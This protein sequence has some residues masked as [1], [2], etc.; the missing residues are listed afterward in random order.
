METQTNLNVSLSNAFVQHPQRLFTVVETRIYHAALLCLHR[1]TVDL[2]STYTIHLKDLF[3]KSGNNYAAM[4][5]AIASLLER[6]W[7]N[8][9]LFL[10]LE[11]FKREGCI[12]LEFNPA[13]AE[14]LLHADEY[15]TCLPVAQLQAAGLMNPLAWRLLWLLRSFFRGYSK[16]KK[17][18][19]AEL[20][21]L[22]W[23]NQR[24]STRY[25][26]LKQAIDAAVASLKAAGLADTTATTNKRGLVAK[27]I[28]FTIPI[29]HPSASVA[30]SDT[31]IIAVE[32]STNSILF[33]KQEIAEPVTFSAIVTADVT[34]SIENIESVNSAGNVG[35]LINAVLQQAKPAEAAPDKFSQLYNVL[36]RKWQLANWQ[37]AVI[38]EYVAGDNMKYEKV[39][40]VIR[41]INNSE[42]NTINNVG[43]VV[44][45][46]YTKQI[47]AIQ[48][49]AHQKY[50]KS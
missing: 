45:S 29:L 30:G 24:E 34:K 11:Y 48:L 39:R 14:H 5:V 38:A 43:A 46:A 42:T 33:V 2:T 28:D 6:R 49:L 4:R 22:L 27:G 35:G 23:N 37:V 44:W 20:E 19:N 41:I 36:Q 17:L 31:A 10:R 18:S 13:L 15:Y 32:E 3:S 47:P 16:A 26:R 25:S 12:E 1:N 21:K 50:P 8:Q 9:H 40:D 7:F